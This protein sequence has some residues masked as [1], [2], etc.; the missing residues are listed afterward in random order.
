MTK[1]G[2]LKNNKVKK[3]IKQKKTKPNLNRS[4]NKESQR[5]NKKIKKTISVQKQISEYL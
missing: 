5:K 1:T 2:L 3:F 4:K